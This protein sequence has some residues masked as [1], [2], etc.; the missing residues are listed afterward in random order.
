MIDIVIPT[1]LF[2]FV[3][4]A[5]IICIILMIITVIYL[6]IMITGG[7][8]TV[9]WIIS[10]TFYGILYGMFIVWSTLTSPDSAYQMI[11]IRWG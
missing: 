3:K 8:Y 1:S 4:W 5:I 2:E 6:D 9:W 7:M 10:L 11:S